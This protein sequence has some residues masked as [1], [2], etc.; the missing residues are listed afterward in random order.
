MA[1]ARFEA[2]SGGLYVSSGAATRHRTALGGEIGLFGM[3]TSWSTMRIGAVGLLAQGLP[4]YLVGGVVGGRI[5]APTRFS[6]YLGLSGMAG[7]VQTTTVAQ[8]SYTDNNGNLVAAGQ[9]V[10]SEER[11]VGKE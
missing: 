7:Y 11:R 3:P 6:P 5:H 2:G 1:D 4:N 9:T 10:R 8:D